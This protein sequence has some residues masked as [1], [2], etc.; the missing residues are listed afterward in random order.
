MLKPRRHISSF[1]QLLFCD[2]AIVAPAPL[3]MFA[4]YSAKHALINNRKMLATNLHH[5]TSR[6]QEHMENKQRW[7]LNGSVQAA[8]VSE[9]VIVLL[10][11]G[12]N[13]CGSARFA[14]WHWVAQ[15]KAIRVSNRVCNNP[16]TP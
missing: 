16:A 5:H 15:A 7:Q 4:P 1:V 9:R 2:I 14:Q 6:V 11:L 13:L 3:S 12:G 10:M 8:A